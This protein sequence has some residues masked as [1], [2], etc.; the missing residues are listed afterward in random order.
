[1]VHAT[2]QRWVYKFTPLIETTFKERRKHV[3]KSWR[4][5]ETYIKVKGQWMYQYRAVDKKETLL[6]SC[7]PKEEISM[8]HINSCSKLLLVMDALG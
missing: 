1:M 4:M 2:L 7:S 8:L 5:D 6:I 3:G